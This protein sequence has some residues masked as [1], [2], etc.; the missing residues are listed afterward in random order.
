MSDTQLIDVDL[1]LDN[2]YLKYKSGEKL[3]DNLTE[4]CKSKNR[5]LLIDDEEIKKSKYSEYFQNMMKKFGIKSIKE[6][7]PNKKKEFLNA[8]DR[9][10]KSEKEKISEK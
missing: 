6:L 9:G 2:L 7:D 4:K 8:I 5:V 3:I 1:I 10:W